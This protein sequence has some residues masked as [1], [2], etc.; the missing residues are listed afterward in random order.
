MVRDDFFWGS[1]GAA[2]GSSGNVGNGADNEDFP[3]LGSGTKK[4][5]PTAAPAPKQPPAS[6]GGKGAKGGKK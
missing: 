3:A 5:Q 6:S 1:G 2:A 4:K